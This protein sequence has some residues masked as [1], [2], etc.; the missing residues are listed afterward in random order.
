MTSK[1]V[2]NNIESDSGISSV[3]FNSNIQIGTGTTIH[4]SGIDL[5]SGNITGGIVTATSF[6][7]SAA[8]L[9]NI[10]AG[11]LSGTLPALDG[12]ALTGVGVGT[13]DSINTSGIITATTFNYTGN[14]NLSHRNIVINGAMT[15]AQ[16][17]TSSAGG[18]GYKTVDRFQY[19]KSGT[20][21]TPNQAQ[22]DVAAGTTPYTLGFRKAY[23]VENGNQLSPGASDLV[24][25]E[26]NLEAQDLANCGW[27]YTSSSSYITLSFWV[28]SSVAQNFYGYLLTVDGTAYQ[29]PFETGSLS[30]NTWTKVT[31]TIPGNSNLQFDNNNNKG[32]GIIWWPFLGDSYTDPGVSLNT[33]A[34]WATGTRTPDSTN[35]W[36][37]TNDA[38]FQITG[39]QLEVG[40]VATP[41]EHRSY[42][43]EFARCQRYYQQY[44]NISA[45][46]YVPNNGSRTYSHGFFFPVEMRSAPTMSITNTGSSNGQYITD[47]SGNA[48]VS[49][50]LS[51]G[52]KTTHM[53]VSFNISTDLTD[54]RGA[55][56]FGTENTTYQTTY[57]IAAEI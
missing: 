47:G 10:P 57:K 19:Y 16:R 20:N 6:S 5:G 49:S 52:S 32:L 25:I 30:A 43:E 12:S 33:W 11:N 18:E 8:N 46:G 24:F 28:K 42:G 7:G 50:V 39:V 9:T 40:P 1:I 51:Q 27:N 37:L 13:A 55:Y 3:T 36:Y 35:T 34:T 21:E 45:V 41:F 31:K 56:L 26:T 17:G 23:Q 15:I 29:Y 2:V 44:V 22:V 4:S 14:Q 38:T 48:Y 54:Y 53:S